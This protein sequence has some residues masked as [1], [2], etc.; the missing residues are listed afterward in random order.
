[1]KDKRNETDASLWGDRA[2]RSLFQITNMKN[3]FTT[4]YNISIH[5]IKILHRHTGQQLSVDTNVYYK[6]TL[7]NKIIAFRNARRLR[8]NCAR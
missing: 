2:A 8:N 5:A 4:R 6:M 3:Y 7:V 1:M